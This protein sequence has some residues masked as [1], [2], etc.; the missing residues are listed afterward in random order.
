MVL[1]ATLPTKPSQTATSV[2]PLKRSRPSTLPMKLMPG[3]ARSRG[4]VSRVRAL[5][6]ESSSPM[7]SRPT[8]GLGDA[9]NVAGVHVAHDGELDEV[10]GVAV[11]VGARHRAAAKGCR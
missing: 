9:E 2:W 11:D 6:L 10:V 8:R 5:P 7:E 1:R 3:S 4:S